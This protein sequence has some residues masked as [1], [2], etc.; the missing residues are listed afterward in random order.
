MTD[1]EINLSNSLLTLILLKLSKEAPY[2]FFLF[3]AAPHVDA[4]GD[5]L[6]NLRVAQPVHARRVAQ[7]RQ[8]CRRGGG[9]DVTGTV[10]E[11]KD[12][13]QMYLSFRLA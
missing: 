10:G 9:A 7:A 11:G 12:R 6:R 8:L 13:V 3:L 2:L 5:D 1:G 4:A